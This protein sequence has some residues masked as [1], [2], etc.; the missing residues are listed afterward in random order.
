M[1]L[2]WGTINKRVFNPRALRSGKWQ[3]IHHVG[4]SSGRPYRTPVEATPV[5]D[6]Y[7][8]TLVY[9][10]RSDW[11]RNVLTAGSAQLEI[12]GETVHVGDPE[13]LTADEAFDRLPAD[14]ERPPRML[15][16]DEFLALR[17]TGAQPT[18]PADEASDDLGGSRP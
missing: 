6:G 3:V 12:G 10:R 1:P 15:R 17:R 4:R 2:W 14:A 13:I 7:I 9:G 8:V 11:V 16:I 5:D 18:R